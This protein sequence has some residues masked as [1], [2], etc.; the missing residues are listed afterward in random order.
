MPSVVRLKNSP[1]G[2]P[3]TTEV[4]AGLTSVDASTQA[5]RWWASRGT[6]AVVVRMDNGTE[7]ARYERKYLDVARL[8][9]GWAAS[10]KPQ[11][12]AERLFQQAAVDT[13]PT[14]VNEEPDAPE[15]PESSVCATCHGPLDV[16]Y[17]EG[18]DR[19]PSGR[20]AEGRCPD[21]GRPV[22]GVPYRDI[23]KAHL[24]AH[25]S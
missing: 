20:M 21:C 10:K 19:T 9:E 25:C 11:D 2:E 17:Q 22:P 1:K 13:Q 15:P 12:P 23:L 4:K 8:P 3:Y 18:R 14:L 6:L 16:A 7:D 5:A 24:A